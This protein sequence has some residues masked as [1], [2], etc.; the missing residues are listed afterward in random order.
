MKKILGVLLLFAISINCFSQTI[1]SLPI[2]TGKGVGSFIPIV[3][4]GVTKKILT[5]SLVAI[6]LVKQVY[7][8]T[9]NFTINDSTT[10]VIVNPSAL[11]PSLTLVMPTNPTDGQVI[12]INFGGTIG[13]TNNVITNFTVL[14]NSSQD[15][16]GDGN[17]G[18]VGTNDYIA[19]KYNATN[20]KWYKK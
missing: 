10:W 2:A 12:D 15:I 16:I 17:Y 7:T 3:Q 5:D 20:S 1:S 18:I 9:G 14:T 19:Y 4:G 11:L 8:T 13:G 6:K